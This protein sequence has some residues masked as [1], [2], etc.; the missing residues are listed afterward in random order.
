MA[1]EWEEVVVNDEPQSNNKTWD[2]ETTIVGVLKE[3]KS[4]IGKYK[5]N[6]YVIETEDGTYDVWG[7]VVLDK[8]FTAIEPGSKVKIE[9][10]GEGTSEFGKYPIYKVSQAKQEAKEVY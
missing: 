7:S 4:D 8:A 10:T 3:K 5:Y 2:K 1:E 6:L 9:K